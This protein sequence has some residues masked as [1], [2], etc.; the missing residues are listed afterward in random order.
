M[1]LRCSGRDWHASHW[2]RRLR[3]CQCCPSCC[4]WVCHCRRCRLIQTLSQTQT[5]I[6][7]QN[8]SR[9]QSVGASVISSRRLASRATMW[10]TCLLLVQLRRQW[11]SYV[12]VGSSRARARRTACGHA[13]LTS[14]RRL[15][16]YPYPYPGLDPCCGLRRGRVPCFGPVS[17]PYPY[18]LEKGTPLQ[19]QLPSSRVWRVVLALPRGHG[20]GRMRVHGRCCCL[21]G[22]GHGHDWNCLVHG[23]CPS[24]LVPSPYPY[25]LCPFPLHRGHG[26]GLCCRAHGRCPSRGRGRVLTVSHVD[27]YRG[28]GHVHGR[29]ASVD[30]LYRHGHWV[31]WYWPG[32]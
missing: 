5:L 20:H 11:T 28:R 7:N 3:K 19:Q 30:D 32:Q 22:R 4:C 21:H 23:L 12:G 8:Q 2:R 10:A 24:C 17:D 26:H 14:C 6:R 15:A 1:G 13:W 18:P 31:C 27:H 29:A 9:N 25:Y 16:P